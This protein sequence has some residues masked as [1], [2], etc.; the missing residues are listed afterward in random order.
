MV[1]D[2]L[3]IELTTRCRLACPKCVRTKLTK[4]NELKILDFPFEQ[5][6]RLCESKIYETM[7]FGGTYGDCIYHPRFYD[8]VKVAK[9][10]GVVITIHTNGSGKSLEWWKSILLLL[11]R[12]DCLNIA[13]DG[14]K[15]TVGIYR[16]NFTEKD[17]YKN[18][19]IFKLARIRKI[20]C[21]WTFIPMRFN[22]HQIEDAKKLAKQIDVRFILKKSERWYDDD[23]PML[24][25]DKNLI[26]THA[27]NRL[28]L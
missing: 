13:M 7:F 23:D 4:R 26:A 5:F 25:R 8:M 19:E 21:D 24:P 12:R 16:V 27:R 15:E 6:K 20:R 28:K 11:D 10:N 3:D 22:E 14:Y 9:E 18:I 1:L 2:N 17:F